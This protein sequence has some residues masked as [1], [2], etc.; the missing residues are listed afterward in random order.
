MTAA[1][2]AG[3]ARAASAS[4]PR[5]YRTTIRAG[6]Y[7]LPARIDSLAPTYASAGA[8]ASSS[9]WIISSVARRAATPKPT[10]TQKA[11]LNPLVSACAWLSP[12]LSRCSV[13]VVK[14][15]ESKA[16]PSAPP[17]CCEVLISPD[18]RPASCGATPASAAIDIG[19]NE[20]PRPTP[21]A[22]NP[23][24]RSTR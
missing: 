12:C 21:I 2:G 13:R 15:V 23:G 22:K 4:A 14:T 24:S 11:R 17:I 1:A 20:K 16:T 18:A 7:G 6:S 19:T 5:R 3:A 9:R 10:A 8:V